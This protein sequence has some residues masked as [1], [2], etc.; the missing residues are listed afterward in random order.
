MLLN[1]V[2]GR[3][4]KC[5]SNGDNFTFSVC[6]YGVD[7]LIILLSFWRQI[8]I[9][10]LLWCKQVYVFFVWISLSTRPFARWSLVGAAITSMIRS[11]QKFLI[12]LPIWQRV[13]SKRMRR[14]TPCSFMELSRN[15]CMLFARACSQR[16]ADE[17]FGKLS[18]NAEKWIPRFL[19]LSIGPQS[20]IASTH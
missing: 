4:P 13:W 12:C 17:N 20:R 14:G 9:Q 6:R 16:S 2:F 1:C 5:A 7:I 11:S 18:I 15:F 3:L 10:R 8:V 19:L